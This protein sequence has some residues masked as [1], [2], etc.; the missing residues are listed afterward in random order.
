[1][2]VRQL[3]VSNAAATTAQLDAVASAR[4]AAA[5]AK[6]QLAAVKAEAAQ[7][8]AAAA[9]KYEALRVAKGLADARADAGIS[10]G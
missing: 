4:A 2:Y 10:E 6:E 8:A 9:E 7:D 5:A 3:L 1:M